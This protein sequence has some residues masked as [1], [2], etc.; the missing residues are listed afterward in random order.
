M[1]A[2]VETGTAGKQPITIA[3]M[4]DIIFRSAGRYNGASTAFLPEIQI[5]LGVESYHTSSG[6]ATC[7]LDTDTI[8]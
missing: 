7:G 8:T 3:D 4:Y 5:M 2:T 1:G 6:G